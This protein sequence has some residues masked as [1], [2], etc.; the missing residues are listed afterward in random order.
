ARR[1]AQ[2]TWCRP[3]ARRGSHHR[4]SARRGRRRLGTPR[5]GVDA[6]S[7]R[8]LS[9]GARRMTTALPDE[10]WAIALAALPDMG[11]AR[12]L[13]L[14]RRWPAREAWHRVLDGSAFDDTE[15]RAS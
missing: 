4:R 10:A 12:L 3:R 9:R 2:R 1:A 13:A 14:M 15:L 6:A 7:G 11:P 5:V 8:P